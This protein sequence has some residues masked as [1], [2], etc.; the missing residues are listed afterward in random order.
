MDNWIYP[1]NGMMSTSHSDYSLCQPSYTYYVKIINTKK[2]SD[3]IVR[4]WHNTKCMFRS[5]EDLKLEL[6]KS[7]SSEVPSTSSFQVGYLEPPSNTKRWLVE[8]RD[9]EVMYKV[10]QPGAKINLWCDAKCDDNSNQE[11]EPPLRKK[12]HRDC[13]EEEIEE[14]FS[15]LRK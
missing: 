6:M 15:K 1:E 4:M 2:K 14:V 12:S 7:F 10:F 13:Q 11:N 3:F 8:E 9:L 5:P